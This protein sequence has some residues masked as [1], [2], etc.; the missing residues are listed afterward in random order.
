MWD[1]FSARDTEVVEAVGIHAKAK[2]RL[3]N[4]I[5]A[6]PVSCSGEYPSKVLTSPTYKM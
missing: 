4:P 6:A 5:T 3:Q 1:E 2:S